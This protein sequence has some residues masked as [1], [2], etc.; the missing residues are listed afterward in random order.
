[1]AA[2][3]DKITLIGGWASPFVMRVDIALNLKGISYENLKGISY[4]MLQE[5]VGKKSDL[6]LAS[7]PIYKKIPV[8]IHNGTPICESMIIL[9]YIDETWSSVGTPILP[10]DSHDRAIARFWTAYIDDKLRGSIVKSRAM[11]KGT[12]E[13]GAEAGKMAAILQLL[14]ETFGKCSL[15]KNF[16]GGDNIGC[17]D[18]AVGS[19]LGWIKAVEKIVGI[20]FLDEEKVPGLVAW[21][22]RFCGHDAVKEIMPEADKLVEFTAVLMRAAA[23]N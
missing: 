15:G 4:E 20:K 1:M 17:L 14:E 23:A 3:A 6:L 21:S 13:A 18:I 10:S 7:N 9:E 11:M 5:T 16:F 8:L 2:K 12:P 19:H 22:E